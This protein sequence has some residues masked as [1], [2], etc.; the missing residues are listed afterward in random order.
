MNKVEKC[1]MADA[2]SSFLLANK[3]KQN[4]WFVRFSESVTINSIAVT[5]QT[6]RWT[7]SVEF[8]GLCLWVD[9]LCS[10]SLFQAENG[11][12]VF[13]F[14]RADKTKR[15][16]VVHIQYQTEWNAIQAVRFLIQNIPVRV[17]QNA[18]CVLCMLSMV[19]IWE[20]LAVDLRYA[21]MRQ[22]HGAGWW[23]LCAGV[24]LIRVLSW[25]S[26]LV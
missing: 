13:S 16:F 22:Q 2:F 24:A 26:V 4:T 7:L 21:N 15:R 18:S 3:T 14:R 1:V 11:I 19:R 6:N 20:W 5:Q 9:D 17:V 12:D 25:N 8:G 10:L 23:M